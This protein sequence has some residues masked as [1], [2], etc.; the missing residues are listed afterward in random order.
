MYLVVESEERKE[1]APNRIYSCQRFHIPESLIIGKTMLQFSFVFC[2]GPCYQ[3]INT[4][5]VTILIC[6]MPRDETYGK[7]TYPYATRFY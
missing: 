3:M 5:C 4:I 1:I 7:T 6:K 2:V